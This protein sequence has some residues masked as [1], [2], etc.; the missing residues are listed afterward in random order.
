M[1]FLKKIRKE[2][3][4]IFLVIVALFSIAWAEKKQGKIICNEIR[5][6]IINPEE[7]NFVSE[8]EIVNLIS[9]D[10]A[11]PLVGNTYDR[12]NLKEIEARAESNQYIRE[13]EA[14]KDHKGDLIIDA[15][16]AVPI[17]RIMRPGKPDLYVTE[18]GDLIQTSPKYTSRTL[19]ITGQY[20]NNFSR[21]LKKDTVQ[22]KLL[23]LLQ[24]ID[25]DPFWKAQI[26][27]IDMDKDADLGLYPEVSKQYIQFG[28]L[29][30]WR[31][32][33]FKLKIFYDK[34]LPFKGWN[35]YSKVN[36]EYENQIICE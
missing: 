19:L 21:S 25:K 4:V 35:A 22:Q 10:R 28:N 13:A 2:V 30:D 9:G 15:Y 11:V 1:K 5:V 6:N 27:Q 16:V 24:F 29:D 26:T 36:L 20:V 34:I 12:I 32:K 3:K 8:K 23:E 33:M 14:F 18:Q 7:S 31:K 17:A